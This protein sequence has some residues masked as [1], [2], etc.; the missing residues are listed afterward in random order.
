MSDLIYGLIAEFAQ[1]ELLLQATQRARAAGYRRLNAYA[2]FPVEGLS[3]SLGYERD[4][5]APLTLAG[6][7]T[8]G[9]TAYLMQWYCN[10]IDYPL[11][12]G[13]R[14]LNSWPAFVP[15][16]F[17][18]TVLGAALCAA[19][20]MLA[21]NGLPRLHHPVFEVPIFLRASR[22]R[23]FLAVQSKDPVFEA[24][25]TSEFLNSLGAISVHVIPG[26]SMTQ[27]GDS[28]E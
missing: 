23:F 19:L 15:V 16:T 21:S 1:P 8:G 14:P 20:G 3:E 18:L 10:V 11:N 17:E 4:C 25:R 2:P 22:D 13:S 12:I 27:T 28:H 26:D 7:I 5:I 6:G 9:L 24:D